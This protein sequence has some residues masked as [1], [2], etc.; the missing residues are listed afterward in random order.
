L[1]VF[2]VL[3]TA[4][5]D[6]LPVVY[7]GPA[8]PAAEFDAPYAI[9]VLLGGDLVAISDSFSQT[10]L[11]DFVAILAQA[12]RAMLHAALTRPAAN[13]GPAVESGYYCRERTGFAIDMDN[14]ALREYWSMERWNCHRIHWR[15]VQWPF[16]PVIREEIEFDLDQLL[17]RD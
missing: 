15:N 17:I 8:L 5:A 4:R 13:R 12:Q 14:A 3:A 9:R 6:D 2:G 1:G 10:M 11:R 7:H 16:H